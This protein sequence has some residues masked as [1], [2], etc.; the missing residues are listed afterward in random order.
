MDTETMCNAP[1]TAC[2]FFES[3][4]EWFTSQPGN[5]I[6]AAIILGIAVVAAVIINA[7]C[8]AIAGKCVKDGEPTTAGLIL[9]AVGKPVFLL[10][11]A[12][13]IDV[14]LHVLRITERAEN[15]ISR[16]YQAVFIVLAVWGA[17]RIVKVINDRTISKLEEKNAVYN[18]LLLNLLRRTV[19]AVVWVVAIL[20]IAKNS[21]N[22]D[23]TAM[24]AGAGVIGLAIAFA[25]QNTI[26]NIFGAITLILDKPFTVGDRILA[27]GK[28]G[29]VES[30]GLRSTTLRTLNG[31]RIAVPNKE[32]SEVSIENLSSR[33]NFKQTFDIGLVYSTTDAQ[34]RRAVEILH[35]ILDN[36]YGFD[37]QNFPPKIA[38]GEMKDFSLNI[39]V[40]VWFPTTDFFEMMGLREKVNFE[41][42]KRFNEE[43]LEFAFPSQT[44]YLAGDTVRPV[45]VKNS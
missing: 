29:I 11:I 7:V 44:L 21:F 32:L 15:I 34:M 16:T 38:F 6:T 18:V 39:G 30:I 36:N 12:S 17:L 1:E 9:K 41:I 20:F 42:L 45:L 35:E 3:I 40:V 22:L 25:A 10:L 23:I 19:K 4:A 5:L 14:A 28:D 13:G 37:M 2:Q 31:T 24:L 33:S 26:A 8:R 27:G 43:K